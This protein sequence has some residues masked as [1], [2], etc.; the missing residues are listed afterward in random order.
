MKN[1]PFFSSVVFTAIYSYFHQNLTTVYS[2]LLEL[3]KYSTIDQKICLSL[4][5][6]KVIH[7]EMLK[8]QPLFRVLDGIWICLGF[9]A[10]SFPDW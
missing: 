5:T 7:K 4:K 2:S 8:F 10:K 9:C 6:H 1:G 3:I